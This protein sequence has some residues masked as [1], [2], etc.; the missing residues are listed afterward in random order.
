MPG[1]CTEGRWMKGLQRI[2]STEETD[3][4]VDLWLMVQQTQLTNHDDTITWK[5]TA[6]GQYSANSA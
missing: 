3:Q 5:H 2:S 1:G 6:S 4:F